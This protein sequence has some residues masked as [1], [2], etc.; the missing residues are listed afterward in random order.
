MAI[1][2]LSEFSGIY[3]TADGTWPDNTTGQITPNDLKEGIK[4]TWESWT[5]SDSTLSGRIS[6]ISGSYLSQASASGAY[7]PLQ[8]TGFIVGNI[9]QGNYS[10][11]QANTGFHRA[12]GSGRA[13]DDIKF[14]F[15]GSTTLYSTAG[16][17]D[18]NYDENTVDF[19]DNSN[20]DDRLFMVMQMNHDWAENTNIYPHI[21]WIQNQSGV[22]AWRIDY[23]V[24]P[25]GGQVP[26]WTIGVAYTTPNVFTFSSGT[27]MQITPFPII[28]GIP[29]LS[30]FGVSWFMDVRIWR[31]S[32]SDTY[33][34]D[35]AA[36]EFDIHYIRN[37]FGSRQQY[38]K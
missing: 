15:I 13:F 6:S 2:T 25:N 32:A 30:G 8:P 14:P 26:A 22:P 21:H 10:E 7:M 27:I 29:T 24:Y 35:A 19:Q 16:R 17:I 11:F 36:K 20:A 5:S 12:Y 9:S 23:R 37:D 34:G 38:I 31:D 18:Y 33:V 28:S 4:D 3:L 1:R